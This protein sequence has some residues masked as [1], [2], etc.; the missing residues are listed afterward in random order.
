MKAYRE[1]LATYRSGTKEACA[2]VSFSG[3]PG[4]PRQIPLETIFSPFIPRRLGEANAAATPME[5]V[6]SHRRFV[7]RGESGSGR[8][9][10][11][12]FLAL[13]CARTPDSPI[14]ILVS[15]REFQKSATKDLTAFAIERVS[16]GH[17]QTL[18]LLT[19]LVPTGRL[20]WLLDDFQTSSAEATAIEAQIE[21][22]SGSVVVTVSC[23]IHSTL[24]LIDWQHYELG[25]LDEE[26]ALKLLDY[27]SLAYTETAEE[28]G[29]RAARLKEHYRQSPALWDHFHSPFNVALYAASGEGEL[30]NNLASLYHKGLQTLAPPVDQ[31]LTGI[32]AIGWH[33][34]NKGSTTAEELHKSVAQV[35]SNDVAPMI[36]QSWIQNGVLKS[37][38]GEIS[39]GKMQWLNFCCA[40]HL[41]SLWQRG[42]DDAFKEYI[43]PHLHHP[44]WKEVHLLAAGLI[45]P[46]KLAPLLSSLLW[47]ISPYEASLKRDLRLATKMLGHAACTE[48]EAKLVHKKLIKLVGVP[49]WRF[50][51]ILAI[52]FCLG[53]GA[54]IYFSPPAIIENMVIIWFG[55]WGLAFAVPYFPM[56]R[57]SLVLPARWF[58]PPADTSP[59]ILAA[60]HL[61]IWAYPVLIT[62]LAP[63]ETPDSQV[64]AAKRLGLIGREESVEPLCD[65]LLDTACRQDVREAAAE[66][67]GNI[68][69]LAGVKSLSLA[70]RHRTAEF[71]TRKAAAIALAKIDAPEAY[72]ALVEGL[73]HQD[74][75]IRELAASAVG[76]ASR[77]KEAVEQLI[78]LAEDRFP[79]VRLATVYSMSLLVDERTVSSL[80]SLL[81]D[82]NEKVRQVA[83][84][85]LGKF[86]NEPI[87]AV[88]QW[89]T[90]EEAELETR[91]SAIEALGFIGT[92]AIVEHAVSCFTF[93]EHQ[94]RAA[95]VQS[96]TKTRFPGVVPHLV[97]ATSDEW[98]TVRAPALDGLTTIARAKARPHLVKALHDRARDVRR[99]AIA[100]L[101]KL[102]TPGVASDLLVTLDDKD[103]EVR[104]D[105]AKALGQL[106]DPAATAR[107]VVSLDDVNSHVREAAV[108]ALAAIGDEETVE[109]IVVALAD[110]E[111]DVR[112]AAA[113]AVA[114]FGAKLSLQPL[115]ELMT[116]N[117]W[118]IRRNAVAALGAAADANSHAEVLKALSDLDGEV[119]CTAA[120]ALARIG[121]DG[122]EEHLL[123]LLQ[124]EME[125]VRAQAAITLG[126]IGSQ[127]SGTHLATALADKTVFVRRAAAAALGRLRIAAAVGNL[128]DCLDDTSWEVR[129]AAARALGDLGTIQAI[130]PLTEILEAADPAMRRH[131]LDALLLLCTHCED[132]EGLEAVAKALW[133]RLTDERTIAIEAFHAL[134][135][136]AGLMSR[137]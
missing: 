107:L 4:S 27:L 72:A 54:T 9:T 110:P 90:N 45:A 17:S 105:G 51:F 125:T 66:A 18:S 47:G 36:V 63:K 12:Q 78:R 37:R 16:A 70:L 86:G 97:K 92:P 82:H 50:P 56:F 88:C 69:S 89:I 8:S 80:V 15:L 130:E 1:E 81:N 132:K 19:R 120:A 71:D 101:Y 20:L 61:G 31:P 103:F 5:A 21:K 42:G 117:D 65:T 30:P 95:A 40:C 44:K 35:T 87:P 124:D 58:K 57:D 114:T 106:G 96:L 77:G 6:E 84:E 73:G 24:T 26:G 13:T 136:V 126:Y 7:L 94:L 104:R 59:F 39:F 22:L 135:T 74:H 62:A 43:Q 14:P 109:H 49:D 99:V 28:A 32:A 116:I 118:M 134:E 75:T 52:V 119:R 137:H 129:K 10:F 68:A 108:R 85:A 29:Q 38:Q 102:R 128:I 121:D 111:P 123:P 91:V 131:T 64:L 11:L 67:L 112:W 48:E 93:P 60:Y 3:F 55:L 33:L 23:D 122:V 127:A 83:A 76:L 53:L 115:T 34:L 100:S 79:E 46:A 113:E 41:A 133:W 98:P 25:P 2:A